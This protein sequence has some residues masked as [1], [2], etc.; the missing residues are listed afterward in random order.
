MNSGETTQTDSVCSTGMNF[1][2]EVILLE[3]NI[4]FTD[5]SIL[6]YGYLWMVLVTSPKVTMSGRL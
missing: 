6:T 3:S 5:K 4:G 1:S 2:F